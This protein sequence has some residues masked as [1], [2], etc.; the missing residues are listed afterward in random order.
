MLELAKTLAA[1]SEYSIDPPEDPLAARDAQHAHGKKQ[2][3]GPQ[4]Q[5]QQQQHTNAGRGS[6]P[7]NAAAGP[8]SSTTAST[9]LAAQQSI[10]PPVL[11]PGTYTTTPA[12]LT[13]GNQAHA[14][15]TYSLQLAIAA[16]EQAVME[17]EALIDAAVDEMQGMS[18]AAEGF[19]ASVRALQSGDPSAGSVG[20]AKE[21][22]ISKGKGRQTGPRGQ[23]ALLPK[24][25]FA[26]VMR[27]G[28][29]AR[30]VVIPYAV[31]EGMCTLSRD[32]PQI[33]QH[34]QSSHR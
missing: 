16:K 29:L 6:G 32:G 27:D 12:S 10:E 30:D 9:S 7:L 15:D 28:D 4:P 1:S 5:K 20:G 25:D 26:R 2:K 3:R 17:C 18:E 13:T 22:G 21:T 8:S 31:D 34:H 33:G 14:A 24:P 19:W 23:W 11:P